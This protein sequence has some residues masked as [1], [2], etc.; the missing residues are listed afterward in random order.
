MQKTE[1][2]ADPS[3]QQCVVPSFRISVESFSSQREW[4][5]ALVQ[6]S[7]A[8]RGPKAMNFFLNKSRNTYKKKHGTKHVEANTTTQTNLKQKQTHPTK[9]TTKLSQMGEKIETSRRNLRRRHQRCATPKSQPAARPERPPELL[10]H[11]LS[12]SGCTTHDCRSL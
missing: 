4:H 9:H 11:G 5:A 10:H 1:A 12:S 6:K 2:T 8:T 3:N 7:G